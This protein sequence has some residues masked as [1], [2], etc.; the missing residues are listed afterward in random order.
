MKKS[1]KLL[2]MT[3]VG[4]KLRVNRFYVS[5]HWHT[6]IDY[7]VKP[8]RLNGNPNGNLLFRESE[9]DGMVEKWQAVN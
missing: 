9:I 2:T 8:I 5:R 7:G 1:D 4:D 6:W 3:E